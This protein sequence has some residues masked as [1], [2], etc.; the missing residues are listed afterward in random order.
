MHDAFFAKLNSSGSLQWHTFM[1]SSSHDYGHDIAIDGSGS[2]YGAGCGYGTWGSPVTPY[3]GLLDAFV[4]K[5]S[6]GAMSQGIPLL[7]LDSSDE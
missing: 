3:T 5:L 1:G 6:S 2:V 4:A 7:L